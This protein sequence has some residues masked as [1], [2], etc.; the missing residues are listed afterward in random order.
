MTYQEMLDLKWHCNDL[1]KEV[2]IREYMKELLTTLFSEGEGFSGKRP[3]GNSGWENELAKPLIAGEVLE[4]VV[5][6]DGY[7][8]D[9][10]QDEL[11]TLI[12]ALI[13]AL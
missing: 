9:F 3:F 1:N 5:D 13:E 11:D 8:E 6:E 4:G 2:S 7:A 10:D 12:F